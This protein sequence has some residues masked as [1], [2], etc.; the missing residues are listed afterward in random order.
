MLVF[1]A[2]VLSL[3]VCSSGFGGD[4]IRVQTHQDRPSSDRIQYHRWATAAGTVNGT[5][6]A[7]CVFEEPV[8]SPLRR[9]SQT[10]ESFVSTC[11]TRKTP[12]QLVWGFR[13]GVFI[14][15]MSTWHSLQLVF[16]QCSH[17]PY[18]LRVESAYNAYILQVSLFWWNHFLHFFFFLLP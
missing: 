2:W 1:H 3:S 8:V 6:P 12:D 17:M 13:T 18:W 15:L 7:E 4:E 9:I 10:V 5:T 16:T 14:Q 11:D